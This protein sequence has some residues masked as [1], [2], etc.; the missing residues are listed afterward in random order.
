MKTATIR[1]AHVATKRHA[2][3]AP[4]PVTGPRPGALSAIDAAI[5]LARSASS[6][7]WARASSEYSST[8][9]EW[10]CCM[11]TSNVLDSFRFGS[12][13]GITTQIGQTT[14]CGLLLAH[15]LACA[16]SSARDIG[17]VAHSGQLYVGLFAGSCGTVAA[18]QPVVCGDGTRLTRGAELRPPSNA[19][20][21]CCARSALPQLSASVSAFCDTALGCSSS[22]LATDVC[23]RSTAASRPVRPCQE[24]AAPCVCTHSDASSRR[25]ASK[26]LRIAAR[27]RPPLATV[28]ASMPPP[29][30]QRLIF[31]IRPL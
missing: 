23:P 30:D 24:P 18:A 25:T 28:S 20:R 5:A 22:S 14:R 19:A 8:S 31:K 7:S 9:Y 12:P 11:C 6:S 10:C 15:S 16:S 26:S 13:P 1:S 3:P 4:A 17:A 2:T 27:T 21:I 29:V